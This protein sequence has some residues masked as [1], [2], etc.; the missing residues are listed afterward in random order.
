MDMTATSWHMF[1][2]FGH[3]CHALV[4]CVS[5]VFADIFENHVVITHLDRRIIFDIDFMLRCS[6]FSFRSFHI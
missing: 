1:E 2:W 6:C 3:K 5:H 4:L